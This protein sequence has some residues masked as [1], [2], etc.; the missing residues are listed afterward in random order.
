M[1]AQVLAFVVAAAVCLIVISSGSGGDRAVR[2]AAVSVASPPSAAAL[3]R[4][5]AA[6]RTE[7]SRTYV[8]G[9]ERVTVISAGPINY[10]DANG[11]WQPIDSSLVAANGGFENRGN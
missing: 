7:T 4:E 2:S 6:S 9:S 10:R 8:K 11:D 3:G 1:R 5:L